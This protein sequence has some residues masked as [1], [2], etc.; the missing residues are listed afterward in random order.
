[1]PLYADDGIRISD[2]A[3]ALN[4]LMVVGSAATG[5]LMCDFSD[6]HEYI[7]EIMGRP[8]YT[9]EMGNDSI[10]A[11]IRERAKPDFVAAITSA[12]EVLAAVSVCGALAPL[13]GIACHLAT[14]HEGEHRIS[15]EDT[16]R[17][18]SS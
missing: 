3:T 16:S 1:M 6:M 17:V 15:D 7:E 8:V 13:H 18:W 11:E 5:H 12:Q 14:G 10:A 9:Q 2:I 4:R